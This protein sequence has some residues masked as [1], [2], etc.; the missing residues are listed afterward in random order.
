MKLF[1][2]KFSLSL[3]LLKLVWW[4]T[5]VLNSQSDGTIDVEQSNGNATQHM[6]TIDSEADKEIGLSLCNTND[7]CVNLH[8]ST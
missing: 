8:K 4:Q 2:L 1:D 7:N 5:A 3:S 6:L